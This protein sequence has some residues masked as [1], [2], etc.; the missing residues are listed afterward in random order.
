[1]SSVPKTAARIVATVLGPTGM[2][3]KERIAGFQ[4]S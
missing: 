2:P 4:N 3:A 1:M